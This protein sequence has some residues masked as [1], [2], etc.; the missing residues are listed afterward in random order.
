MQFSKNR[1][2][3]QLYYGVFESILALF[4]R[5][6]L[7]TVFK[8]NKKVNKLHGSFENFSMKFISIKFYNVP[9]FFSDSF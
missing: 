8:I 1:G 9:S 6:P 4:V 7:V 5:D 2:K 3:V